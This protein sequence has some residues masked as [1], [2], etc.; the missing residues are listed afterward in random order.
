M[1]WLNTS[2]SLQGQNYREFFISCYISSLYSLQLNQFI[3]SRVF[4][5]GFFIFCSST[6]SIQF[7]YL[8]IYIE[9]TLPLLIQTTLLG[10]GYTFLPAFYFWRR[11]IRYKPIVT[12]IYHCISFYTLLSYSLQL[13]PSFSTRFL[14][15]TKV[16]I[17]LILVYTSILVLNLLTTAI[18]HNFSDFC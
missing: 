15:L 7:S 4:L 5:F 12:L 3:F 17:P 2:T 13:N 9:I 18:F 10:L 8:S 6:F 11:E 1:E 14:F 16:G